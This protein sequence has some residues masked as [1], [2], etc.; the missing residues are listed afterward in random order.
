MK[1]KCN[2]GKV[3]RFSIAEYQAGHG[4]YSE[5]RCLECGETFGIHDTKVLKPQWK[6][7]VC[8][9]GEIR[10]VATKRIMDDGQ[11]T[12]FIG[13][14][15]RTSVGRTMRSPVAVLTFAGEDFKLTAEA[16]AVVTEL[17]KRRRDT[18]ERDL[19]IAE[20]VR[21]LKGWRRAHG[22][23]IWFCGVEF[24]SAEIYLERRRLVSEHRTPV[25]AEILGTGRR[26][27]NGR[28]KR[29]SGGCHRKAR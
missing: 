7:H 12:L 11:H 18:R 29:D 6:E 15:S 8:E 20:A 2:D 17:I 4:S 13:C 26:C 21:R 1:L 10:Q 5:S 23:G 9:H 27:E 24:S 16:A 28:R 22:A 25:L 19:I 14:P 3:R